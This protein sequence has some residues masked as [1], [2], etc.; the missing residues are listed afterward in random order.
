MPRRLEGEANGRRVVPVHLHGK[1]TEV[2][3]LELWRHSR[4]GE[5][6]WKLEFNVREQ[7]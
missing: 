5:R 7:R 3:R 1:A 2:G 4:D 6:R